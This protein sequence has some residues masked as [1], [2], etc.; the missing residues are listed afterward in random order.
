[1]GIFLTLAGVAILVC[2]YWRWCAHVYPGD[3]DPNHRFAPGRCTR[4]QHMMAVLGVA[5]IAWGVWLSLE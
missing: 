4:A 2:G 1:M 3:H 5:L